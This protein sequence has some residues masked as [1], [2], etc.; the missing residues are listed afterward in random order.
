MID[1]KDKSEVM[2]EMEFVLIL[3]CVQMKL[4]NGHLQEIEQKM[5]GFL[6]DNRWQSIIDQNPESEDNYF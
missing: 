1:K 4:I 3:L 6:K 5:E 2:H